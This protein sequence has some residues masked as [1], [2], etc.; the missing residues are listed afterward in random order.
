MKIKVLLTKE[1]EFEVKEQDLYN[2]IIRNI[3]A[4]GRDQHDPKAV[5]D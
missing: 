1:Q 2:L 4:N 3:E 5:N